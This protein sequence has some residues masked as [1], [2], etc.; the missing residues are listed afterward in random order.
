VAAQVTQPVVLSIGNV[1]VAA[2]NVLYVGVSEIAGLY[3]VNFV[4]PDGVPD[5]DQPV[6]IQIGGQTSP[7]R[8][9]ITFSG[10]SAGA[11][12]SARK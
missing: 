3:Q 6:T 5:G 2:A 10:G 4:V 12:N 9:Y 7:S 1:Q 11:S 8:A